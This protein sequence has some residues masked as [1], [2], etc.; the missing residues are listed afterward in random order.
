MCRLTHVSTWSGLRLACLRFCK[1]LLYKH[2]GVKYSNL[3]ST[4]LN[5]LQL[6]RVQLYLKG[7]DCFEALSGSRYFRTSYKVY[8]YIRNRL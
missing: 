6:Y 2:V 4:A 1:Y 7:M 5:T 3:V 8:K